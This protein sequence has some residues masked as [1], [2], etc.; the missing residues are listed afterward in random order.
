MPGSAAWGIAISGALVAITGLVMIV[1]RYATPSDDPFSAYPHAGWPWLLACHV[2]PTPVFIFFMGSIWWQHV[3]RNWHLVRRRASGATVVTSLALIAFSGY[4]LYFIGSE[5]LLGALRTSHTV[6]GVL[7][8][9]FYGWHSVR[10]WAIVARSRKP[11]V[12]RLRG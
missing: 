12:R 10:G 2:L 6:L 1:F 9:V 3:V 5:R 11:R 8:I 7:G 4:V